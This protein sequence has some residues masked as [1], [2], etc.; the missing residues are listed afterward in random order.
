[1]GQQY[2]Q[3]RLIH[4][5]IVVVSGGIKVAV[6]THRLGGGEINAQV[7]VVV[8]CQRRATFHEHAKNQCRKQQDADA[9]LFPDKQNPIAPFN[10]SH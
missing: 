9:S 8:Y 10:I 3:K 2:R 4:I 5:M 7:G 1:M 6:F